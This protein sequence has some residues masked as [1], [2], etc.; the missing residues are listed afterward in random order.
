MKRTVRS[1]RS[2]LCALH[3]PFWSF[4]GRPPALHLSF[5]WCLQLPCSYLSSIVFSAEVRKVSLPLRQYLFALHDAEVHQEFL[6][7]VH[8]YRRG[9]YEICIISNLLC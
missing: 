7:F 8:G 9:D 5:F 3:G 2:A 1:G 6:Q 4:P